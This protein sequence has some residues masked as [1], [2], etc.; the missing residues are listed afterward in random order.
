MNIFSSEF[1]GDSLYAVG[2]IAVTFLRFLS[3]K[4]TISQKPK[5]TKIGKLFFIG[6]RKLCMPRGENGHIWLLYFGQCS[7]YFEYKFEHI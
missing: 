6:F 5:I 2:D 3:T 4:S 1:L 7:K